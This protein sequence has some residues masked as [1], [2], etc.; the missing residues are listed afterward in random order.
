MAVPVQIENRD[1]DPDTAVEEVTITVN[2]GGYTTKGTKLSYKID[3]KGIPDSPDG[4]WSPLDLA[5]GEDVTL[6]LWEFELYS[7]RD[8]AKG[9][10]TACGTLDG[11]ALFRIVRTEKP[12]L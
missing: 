9:S 11:L 4:L 6:V 2:W 1:D 3:I 8:N 7:Y 5:V 10:C 12:A